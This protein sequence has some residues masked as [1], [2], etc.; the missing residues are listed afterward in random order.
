MYFKIIQISLIYS[1]F[2]NDI[3]SCCGYWVLP[4]LV[5]E[6]MNTRYAVFGMSGVY[7]SAGYSV[8]LKLINK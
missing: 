6:Y 7:V 5:A 4:T 1:N 3:K 8:V 2:K